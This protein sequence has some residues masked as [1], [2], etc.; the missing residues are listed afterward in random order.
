M[1]QG[2][3]VIDVGGDCVDGA[4]YDAWSGDA[5]GRAAAATYEHGEQLQDIPL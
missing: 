5:N 4:G 3:G 2:F 1:L